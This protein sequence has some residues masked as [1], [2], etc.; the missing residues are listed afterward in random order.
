MTHLSSILAAGLFLGGACLA[1]GTAWGGE[2][3][4]R[5]EAVTEM[6][7]VFGQVASRVIVPARARI[8][9]TITEIGVTEGAEVRL[10][11]VVATVVDAKIA[12]QLQ[13]ADAKIAALTSQ[14]ENARVELRRAQDLLVKGVTAQSRVD[15]AKLEFD[16]VTNQLAAAAADKAVI[17]QS[18]KEGDVLAPA[19]GR[20]LTVP[21]TAGSVVMA[22]EPVARIASGRYYLRLSLPERHAAEIVE[23]GRVE[24]SGRGVGGGNGFDQGRAGRIA[25]VYPEIENGRVIAD[26]EIEGVGDYFVNERTLVSIPVAHRTVLGV[27]PHAVRTVHGLDYVSIRTDGAPLDVAVVLGERFEADGQPM[28]EVLSGLAEGDR[29][30]LP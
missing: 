8:S 28:V 20:V 27:P 9:G 15:A 16:V 24:I 23:G 22:G 5:A 18:A 25:K 7:A 10:G 14:L 2:F 13:A 11:D 29:V 26:V 17:A 6:K 12:L 21:M 19:S 4:V 30:L 1:T 3:T